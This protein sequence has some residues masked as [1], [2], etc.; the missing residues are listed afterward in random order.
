MINKLIKVVSIISTKS[1]VSLLSI[2]IVIS[3]MEVLSVFSIYPIFFY[4][5]NSNIIDN[6]YYR[7]LVLNFK[8][9]FSIGIFESIILISITVV[10]FTNTMVFFRYLSKSKIKETVVKKNRKYVLNLLSETTIMHF[11]KINSNSIQ[12]YLTIESERIAQ[13]VLS[14]TNM[15]SALIV[16]ILISGYLLFIDLQLFFYLLVIV[17]LLLIMLRKSYVESKKLGEELSVI[18]EKYIKYIYK[19]ISDRVIFMLADKDLIK[20]SFDVDVVRKLHQTKYDIQKY[21]SYIEFVI[22]TVTMISIMLVMYFF[23]ITNTEISLILFTGLLF[24]RLI[25][26][27]SQFGNALQNFKSNLPLVEKLIYLENKLIKSSYVDLN[28]IELKNISIELKDIELINIKKKQNTFFLES[29]N[30]YGLFGNSGSGKTSLAQSIL[31]LNYYKNASIKLN[32]KYILSNTNK[33]SI[34]RNSSY[35]SQHNIPNEFTINE[36]FS[37]FDFDLFSHYLEKFNFLE[38]NQPQFLDRKLSTFSGG[39]QQKLNFIYTILQEKRVIIFD[40]PTSSMDDTVL[41][42]IMDTLDAYVAEH[43]AIII[44]IS[45]SQLIKANIEK[46]IILQ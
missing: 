21:G 44:I 39:E 36:L 8:D 32:N 22:K 30:I 43:N 33:Q 19:V 31:G 4:M 10:F 15:I 38:S 17:G 13:I 35:L 41:M 9:V 16:I 26:F 34:L 5:E 2:S 14:F 18:N 29:G 24:V 45:H 7:S 12:S 3:L 11:S 27:I 42:T 23:Y 46:A 40:E 6:I 37:G 28:E 25:P 1:T 20:K